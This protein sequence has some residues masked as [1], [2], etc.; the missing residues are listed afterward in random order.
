MALLSAA[1]SSM[2]A[3]VSS[4]CSVAS[5][6]MG[7]SG[8]DVIELMYWANLGTKPLTSPDAAPLDL[9]ALWLTMPTV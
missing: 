5:W 7:S 3:F 2:I 6:V 9:A 1:S 4:T 8:M